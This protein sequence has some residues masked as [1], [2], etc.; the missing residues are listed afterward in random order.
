MPGRVDDV[1]IVW[2]SI[3]LLK[4]VYVNKGVNGRTRILICHPWRAPYH[5]T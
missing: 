5:T 2:C 1:G 3:L 4:G